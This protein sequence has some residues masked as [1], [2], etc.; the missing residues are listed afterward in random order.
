LRP[1]FTNIHD[2]TRQI[3]RRA[4]NLKLIVVNE[5]L[6]LP[7]D[8][9]P[10]LKRRKLNQ[11]FNKPFKSPL[12]ATTSQHST[13][14]VGS[15]L[16]STPVKNA[17]NQDVE[18]P[19][20]RATYSSFQSTPLR[21]RPNANQGIA[22]AATSTKTS[23]PV[24]QEIQNTVRELRAIETAMMKPR[25]DID[26]LNQALRLAESSR[27]VELDELTTKWRTAARQAAEEVFS[28]AR[29]KVNRMGGVGAWRERQQEA[30]ER[31]EE[32]NKPQEQDDEE[33]IYDEEGELVEIIKHKREERFDDEWEYD[34]EMKK[35]K[36][37]EESRDDDVSN[38]SFGCWS[39]LAVMLIVSQSFTMDMM[40][41]MMNIELS[42]IG[43]DK[44]RQRWV[45]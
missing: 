1:Q 28:G 43:Y 24:E 20:A 19:V 6:K 10:A 2:F 8:A 40:L 9:T 39:R 38:Q 22:R 41:K 18:T 30:A 45:G 31:N 36:K 11:S 23:D 29:D 16:A 35:E 13:P 34:A 27:D 4:V 21:P 17:R 33:E 14:H 3:T 12:K 26:A 7:M 44:K 37:K 32:W 5:I 25:Q 42:L 15:P